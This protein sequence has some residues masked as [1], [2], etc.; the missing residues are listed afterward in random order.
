MFNMLQ[1][2]VC[3]FLPFCGILGLDFRL[4]QGVV[5][6]FS[7]FFAFLLSGQ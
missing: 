7:D 3:L 2:F 1:Y 4:D 5:F 6:C